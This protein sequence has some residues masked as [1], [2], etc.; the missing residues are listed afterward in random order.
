MANN[1]SPKKYKRGLNVVADAPMPS[2]VVPYL[3]RVTGVYDPDLEDTD[4]QHSFT[5]LSEP[6]RK[7]QQQ[8][9]SRDMISS[10]DFNENGSPT[11]YA[12]RRDI[13]LKRYES[14][15]STRNVECG[16]CRKEK[17]PSETMSV[18]TNKFPFVGRICKAKCDNW[19]DEG[20]PDGSSRRKGI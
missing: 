18:R 16:R 8:Q 10:D 5:Q 3:E 13:F 7:V 14:V 12:S 4:M 19:N 11:V 15:P 17:L 9:N 20:S 1:T 2:Y 6:A